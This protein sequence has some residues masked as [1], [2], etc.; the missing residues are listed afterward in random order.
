MLKKNGEGKYLRLDDG[1][2]SYHLFLLN[3]DLGLCSQE[4][5]KHCEMNTFKLQRVIRASKSSI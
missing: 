5:L 4:D 3:L 1:A 2:S